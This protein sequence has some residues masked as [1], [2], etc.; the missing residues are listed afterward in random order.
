MTADEFRRMALSFPE[1]V[2]GSHM[3]HADFRVGG[4]IFATLGWPNERY[5]TAM[6]TPQD[7]DLLVK[8]HPKTF[9]P[10]AGAWGASGS[11]TITLRGASKRAVG[12]AL[13][14]AWR[15][16]APKGLSME[17]PRKRASSTP[18][19]AKDFFDR[20]RRFGLQL[21]D[22]EEATSWGV[23]ALKVRGKMFACIPTN[24]QAEPES[25]VFRLSF[26]E[27]DLRLDAEPDRYYLKPHYVN[28]PCVL[29]R[30]KRLSDAAL[31]ELL[32]TSWRFVQT[33]GKGSQAGSQAGSRRR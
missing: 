25:V 23:P 24:K 15:K 29:A 26:T 3:G 31:K 22:V 12:I 11:T 6:L 30:V 19:V 17:S 10:A 20:V 7:Q 2:E 18:R 1:V 28:Y 5:G 32:E 8:D 16:R 13:E 14:A 21:P 33:T 27:R 9:A 4:K